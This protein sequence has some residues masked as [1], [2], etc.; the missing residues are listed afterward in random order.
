[1][2]SFNLK[3]FPGGHFFIQ[4]AE[5]SMLELISGELM[6]SIRLLQGEV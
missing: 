1:M 4:S 3:I 5:A 6:T 2:T